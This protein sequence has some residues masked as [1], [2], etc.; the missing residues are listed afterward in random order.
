M[1]LDVEEW[2]LNSIKKKKSIA[3]WN[4]HIIILIYNIMFIIKLLLPNSVFTDTKNKV[5][6]V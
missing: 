4:T 5:L 2:R 3:K 1:S 6:A